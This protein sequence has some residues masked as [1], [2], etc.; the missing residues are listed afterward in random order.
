MRRL[1]S[2]RA[3][4]VLGLAVLAAL[5]LAARAIAPPESVRCAADGRSLSAAAP[6]RIV[7]V[8]G[9]STRFC[10]VSCADRWVAGGNASSEDVFVLDETTGEELPADEAFFVRSLVLNPAT[11]DRLHVFARRGDAERHARAYAGA[12]LEG[13]E[14]PFSRRV[15]RDGTAGTA[16]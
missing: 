11:R 1:L 2:P 4:Y 3:A 8:S 5:P 14:R 12:I 15:A 10:G 7:S 13:R 6:V 16:P 9:E